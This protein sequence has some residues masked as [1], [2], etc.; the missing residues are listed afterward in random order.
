M[1]AILRNIFRI[2]H[3]SN[4]LRFVLFIHPYTFSRLTSRYIKR[5]DGRLSSKEY[6]RLPLTCGPLFFCSTMRS[7]PRRI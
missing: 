4:G 6:D 5:V 1:F 3:F 7:S 2:P